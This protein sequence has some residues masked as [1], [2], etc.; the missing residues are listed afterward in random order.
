M[1]I[2]VGVSGASGIV[3]G[4]RLAEE[5]N[6]LGHEVHT[7]FTEAAKKTSAY[8]MPDAF[9]RIKRASNAVYGE[10]D[11]DAPPAS[12]SAG[13]EAMV[14]APCSLRTLGSVANGIA[15]NLLTRSALVQLKERRK[16][17]LLIREMPLSTIDI[18]NMLKVSL[19]GGIVAPASPGFYHGPRSIDD[20]VNFVV[21]KVIDLLEIKHGLYRRWKEDG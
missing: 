20:M 14:I 19:A 17:I 10:E 6:A 1:K 4:V 7:I 16:L 15:D 13:F 8:E 2:I 12:G 18:I 9:D 11:I 21:G 5:L 3:Y